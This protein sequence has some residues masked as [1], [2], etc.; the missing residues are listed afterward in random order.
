[1]GA[2]INGL[3][4]S[5]LRP[6]CSTFLSFSDYLKPSIRMASLMNLPCTFV[7]THDSV[8]VGEDG[9]THEP[10]EQLAM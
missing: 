3:A 8:M 4:L 1:M 5:G 7:F 2:F 9:P 6:F 10:V